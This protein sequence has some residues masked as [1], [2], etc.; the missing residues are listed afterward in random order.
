MPST[1]DGRFFTTQ[2]T[3]HDLD[4]ELVFNPFDDRHRLQHA[5][6]PSKPFTSALA[7]SSSRSSLRRR[8]S[9]GALSERAATSP[10]RAES[11]HT[12]S[13]MVDNYDGD[14][15]PLSRRASSSSAKSA[16]IQST[17]NTRPRLTR[18]LS[19]WSTDDAAPSSPEAQR[20]S[21]ETSRGSGRGSAGN[22]TPVKGEEKVVLVHDVAPKD[23]LAGVALKYGISLAELR[24]A[25]QLWTSDS[26]HLRKVL[27]IPVEHARLAKARLALELAESNASHTQAVSQ[28]QLNEVNGVVE[29]PQSG[30]EVLLDHPNR[31]ES[32]GD[33]P[34]KSYVVRR[35][36]AERLS[37]FPSPQSDSHTSHSHL[38]TSHTQSTSVTSPLQS[39]ASDRL[40]DYFRGPGR[41]PPLQS[42][43]RSQT[44]SSATGA[45]HNLSN[46][47]SPV[48][49]LSSFFSGLPI[50]PN[51]AD[52][53]LSRLSIDSATVPATPKSHSTTPVAYP[54]PF[55]KQCH[56]GSPS[57]KRL[58][59]SS[60]PSFSLLSRTPSG[61]K[62]K[63]RLISMPGGK[64]SP[65]EHIPM[66]GNG[67]RTMQMQPALAMQLPAQITRSP[68]KGNATM[69][70][71]QRIQPHVQPEGRLG[72]G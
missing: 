2:H 43:R 63:G 5:S 57:P 7:P 12:R 38:T 39:T 24:R 64:E 9:D 15:H 69:D 55:S 32:S 72:Q 50:I 29:V 70:S 71:V 33:L 21:A 42:H 17:G 60:L 31:P 6:R 65:P 56:K 62:G 37:Y 8:G 23:S 20:Q 48:Q 30:R 4:D 67:I 36:P 53:L 66:A 27:Y 61:G 68:S 59:P 14:H 26:I 19:S 11:A 52:G 45:L 47:R 44:L 3:V 22:G 28:G 35:I 16:R 58:S 49:A 34:F 46:L 1:A 54:I 18:L 25:N 13:R 51:A 41:P 40:P 10:I